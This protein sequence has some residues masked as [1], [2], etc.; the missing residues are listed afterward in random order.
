MFSQSYAEARDRFRTLARERNGALHRW[1]VLPAEAG[2]AEGLTIDAAVFGAGPRVL[3]VS[4]GLHGIEGFA[5]SAIQL[6]FMRHRLPD[7]LRVIVLHVLNPYG[8]KHH[9]RV[10]ERNVDLNRN[11]LPPGEPYRGSTPDYQ[12]LNTLLNPARPTGGIDLMLLQT[13]IQIA[14]HG[15]TALKTAVVGGQYDYPAGLYFGGERLEDGPARL[16]RELP[17]LVGTAD[18]IV[19][20]DIHTGLGKSGTH[21][22][23]VDADAGSAEH[24]R[25]HEQY[26]D[27]VQ[28]WDSNHGLAYKIRGGF[29]SA[30]RRLFGS[31]IDVITCEFGT[32]P[33]L[34]VLRALRIENQQAHW[35]GSRAAAE[36]AITE[37]FRPGSKRW[38]DA[39]LRGGEQVLNRAI[40]HLRA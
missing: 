31:S 20:I 28:P 13:A 34:M 27:R 17:G 38:E 12:R 6:D 15:F 30:M 35:G 29:P 8:M 25:L 9:R 2:E 14:I 5:G 11:F 18:H 21:A 22:L 32:H 40:A 3:I 33:A 26:G 23:F 19:H 24:L 1:E 7:D 39:V 10:N 37:A 16:L 4:S 36:K